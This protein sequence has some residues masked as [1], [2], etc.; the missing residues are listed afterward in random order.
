LTKICGKCN[1]EKTQR[2]NGVWICKPC[3]SEA[4]KKSAKKH[5]EKVAARSK[6]YALEHADEIAIKQHEYY[7]LHSEEIYYRVKTWKKAN[8]EKVKAAN[9]ASMAS[10]GNE[11]VNRKRREDPEKRKQSDANYVASDKFKDTQ[12]RHRH[13]ARASEGSFTSEDWDAIVKAQ[14]GRCIDCKKKVDLTVGHLIPVSLGGISFPANIV[15]QCLACNSSQGANVY[16]LAGN[17]QSI[18]SVALIAA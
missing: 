2:P 12:R 10:V 4:N 8:P 13:A 9:K 18:R 14:R 11:T 3:H 16:V 5:P 17:V 6:K 1:G 7:L 15:G